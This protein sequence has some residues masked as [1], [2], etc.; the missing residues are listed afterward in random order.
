MS[1]G[2]EEKMRLSTQ[3]HNR[4]L[5]NS[6]FVI[7][8]NMEL[9]HLE[10]FVAVVDEGS[11]T[12]AAER[13]G[14][15]KSTVSVRISELEASLGLQLM[16]RSTRKFHLTVR[17]DEL[18]RRGKDIVRSAEEAERAVSSG[19]E[20]IVG[21]VRMSA[22]V[23][24]GSRYLGCVFAQLMA[25]HPKLELSVDLSDAYV[26]LV[27]QHYD[28]ALRVGEVTQP[29]AIVSRL[30]TSRR[31]V[32]GSPEYLKKN[33]RPK[34]PEDLSAH[35]CLLF[36]HQRLPHVWS[37]QR[38]QGKKKLDQDVRVS[39]TLLSNNGDLLALAAEAGAGL[40]WLPEFIVQDSLAAKRLNLVLS[41][42]CHPSL[43]VH[44]V[45]PERRFVPARVREV[46][47]A[48]RGALGKVVT[49]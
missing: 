41:E 7:M 3:M 19:A 37:F 43:P 25:R 8:H 10:T 16:H 49:A 40:A 9:A 5:L 32:V 11:F 36:A 33:G 31:L 45:Y 30:G 28:L 39:G 20:E 29:T 42:S 44:L 21:P 47:A 4:K 2:F 14:V 35:R 15:S 6:L 12:A 34:T 17:G 22:P 48:L 23:S 1:S 13:L 38:S 27:E 46:A 24:L 18:Y 26:D